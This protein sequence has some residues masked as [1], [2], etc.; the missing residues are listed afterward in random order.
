M[1]L[2]IAL[3]FSS[4]TLLMFVVC[5]Q[6]I[7]ASIVVLCYSKFQAFAITRNTAECICLVIVSFPVLFNHEFRMNMKYEINCNHEKIEP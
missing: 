1:L 7:L 3:E 2:F 5:S 4:K 6:A